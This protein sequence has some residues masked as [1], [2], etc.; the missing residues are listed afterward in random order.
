MSKQITVLDSS[1]ISSWLSC[2]RKY[3]LAH[4]EN[5]VPLE[6]KEAFSTGSL[7][8]AFLEG[9]YKA[10][11]EGR[12]PDECVKEG[13]NSGTQFRAA[14]FSKITDEVFNFVL[15]R[16]ISYVTYHS[17]NSWKVKGVE[18]GFSTP[19]L[20]TPERTFILEGRIDLILEHQGMIYF[21][22]HK[23]QKRTY[24]IYQFSPQILDY[25]LALNTKYGLI[26]YFGL[27]ESGDS[28]KW[29]RQQLF[30]FSQQQLNE[31]RME[32]ISIFFDIESKKQ[33][34]FYRKN[35]ASCKNGINQL[36]DYHHICQQTSPEFCNEIKRLE[37]RVGEPWTPWRVEE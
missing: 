35:R 36:C 19:I 17:N 24:D 12:P 30:H 10:R 33:N 23:T 28:S 18:V 13:H 21:C 29:F 14:N 25:A 1:R 2:Q 34:G 5:L 26:N 37:F 9:F 8:H 7:V 27:Q 31:W 32:L 11:M 15:K 16:Y 4:I 20:D 6:E 22:D 3:Q